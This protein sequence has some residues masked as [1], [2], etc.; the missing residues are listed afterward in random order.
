MQHEA[1]TILG[2]AALPV[3]KLQGVSEVGTQQLEHEVLARL[4]VDALHDAGLDKTDVGSM[5]F[6]LPRPYTQQKYFATFMANYLRLPCDGLV[7]EVMGNGMT[8][9]LALQA[10]VDQVRLG[11]TKVALALGVNF[12]TGTP[13]PEH[14][15]SSMRATG[16]VDFHAPFGFTPISWYAMDAMR[17]IHEFGSSREDLA[18]IA[19]KNRHHA[20]ENPIAQFRKP[21]T[22]DDVLAQRPIVDP[23]GLFEVP[24]RGDGAVCLV[25]AREDIAKSTGRPYTRFRG[26]GFFHEGAHQISEVPNDMIAFEAARIAGARAFKAA[27]INPDDIDLAEIYAPCTIVEVL[28][29]EALGFCPRGQGA[30]QA[31]E[32]ET[33]IGGR[34]PICTSGGLLSRGHP[35]Y[36]TAL[37]SYFELLEQLRGRGGPR[38]VKNAELG[39][40]CTELG[41]YNAA[42]VHIM[43]AV[44]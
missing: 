30:K 29:S 2:G 25:I 17:Y 13:A 10:A 35:A 6:T 37:Y 22:L 44:A 36:V 16:D 7:M 18:S 19:V 26:E 1:V 41:N 27:G 38:Q 14:M 33:A 12:E 28:V 11:R 31:T 24:G 9:A 5:V 39:L 20:I 4:V 40:A 43:E 8:P 15:M 23:L 42:M 3:G 21:M 32:G 34:I